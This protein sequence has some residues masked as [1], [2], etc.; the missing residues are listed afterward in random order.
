MIQFYGEMKGRCIMKIFHIS[1][2][3]IG[4]QLKMYDIGEVQQRMLAKIVE[5]AR[6][7]RPD[8]IV[9]AGDIYDK[10]APSGE[11]FRI[12]DGFL[13]ALSELEPE[14]PVFIISGN[15]DNQLRLNY[16]GSFLAKH[17]I[18]IAASLPKT[19]EEYLQKIVLQDKYGVVNFY[20]LPFVRP[21]DAKNLLK[22]GEG[23]RQDGSWKNEIEG[24]SGEH[25][26]LKS[27]AE[28]VETKENRETEE[29]L[30]IRSYDDAVGMFLS[31]EKVDFS[32]RNVLVAHQ[33][34]VSGETAPERRDSEQQYISVG[35]IDSVSTEWVRAYDYVALGHI[36]SR[37][38]IGETH[39][40][41]SGTPWKYSL[42]EEKDEKGITVVDLGE[43]GQT[44]EI[45]YIPLNIKPDVRSVKGTFRE[46]WDMAD[47]DNRTDYVSITLTDE[48]ESA[49]RDS[50]VRL[51]ERYEHI[52]EIMV[53]NSR[54]Q[55]ILERD[56]EE[57][58]SDDPLTLFSIFYKEMHDQPMSEAELAAMKEIIGSLSDG[59]NQE[60]TQ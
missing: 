10:S 52:M 24:I 22:C 58:D 33:F 36:H 7:V 20:L 13:T 18:Y 50:K 35:G 43:K 47:A 19:E 46:V 23:G 53:E 39:I 8:A 41:Y 40:R 54:T 9:I 12:F 28:S 34:F 56:L 26:S 38:S 55:A 21:A 2:L 37:Q 31:R 45:S 32:Q 25:D 60:G 14:I 5:E 27:E 1:D 30:K 4:K 17:H 59:Q 16:A 29:S 42:S 49:L 15:H 3:H 6:R 57:G 44:P 48:D 11:A 51:G